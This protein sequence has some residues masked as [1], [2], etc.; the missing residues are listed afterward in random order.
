MGANVAW[1]RSYLTNRK[2]YI[3]I[4]KD[5][6]TNKQKVTSGVPQG[7]ILGPLLSLIYINNLPSASNFSNTIMFADDVN[8]FLEHKD[9]SVLFWQ[10]IENSRILMNGLFQKNSLQTVK[11][12]RIFNFFIKVIGQMIY[13]LSDKSF[14][15]IIK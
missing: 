13:H 5:T 6:K 12:K 7:S 14:L 4:N 2:Q 8:L 11:K 9:I 3:C 10:W 15:L 1:F